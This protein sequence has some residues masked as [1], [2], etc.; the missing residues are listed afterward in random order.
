MIDTLTVNEVC[1][2]IISLTLLAFIAGGMNAV[3]KI[4]KLPLMV[5]ILIHGTVLYVS[6]LT[7]YILNDWLDHGV[8]PILIF[9]AVFIVGYFAIW[10]VIYSVIRKN[11]VKINE[12]LKQKQTEEES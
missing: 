7:T 10:A 12:K 4:E 1:T 3:Y 5:A 8:I 9:S 2:G 6:Y 11:T